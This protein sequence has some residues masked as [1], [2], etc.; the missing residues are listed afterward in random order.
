MGPE[1]KKEKRDRSTVTWERSSKRNDPPST[2][3]TSEPQC[4]ITPKNRQIRR[5][6]IDK[7]HDHGKILLLRDEKQ[8]DPRK[9]FRDKC[10]RRGWLGQRIPLKISR[11]HSQKFVILFTWNFNRSAVMPTLIVTISFNRML[12]DKNRLFSSAITKYR[13]L[14]AD[15]QSHDQ[16]KKRR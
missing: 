15:E 7:A 8:R 14:E 13:Q 2:N 5:R 16:N 9:I 10:H 4:S 12:T 1:F 11:I 6:R 3:E